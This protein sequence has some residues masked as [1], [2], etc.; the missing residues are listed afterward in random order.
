MP[1]NEKDVAYFASSVK[2]KELKSL[3][4][5]MT[6]EGLLIK[7]IPVFKSGT[8]RGT[9]YSNDYIDR[10][11]IGQFKEEEDIP[12]QA[13]HSP[14][15]LHTL[16]WVKGLQRKSKMMLADFLLTDENAIA[17][18]QKGLMKKFSIGVDTVQEKLREISIVAFPYVKSAHVHSEEIQED[19]PNIESEEVNGTYFVTVEGEQFK[20]EKDDDNFWFLFPMEKRDENGELEQEE[21]IN[22]DDEYIDNIDIKENVDDSEAEKWSAGIRNSLPDSSFLLLKKPVREKNRDRDLPIKDANGVISKSQVQHALDKID[23]VKAFSPDT[24]AK[25]KPKLLRI[26]KKLGIESATDNHS[27]VIMEE[28]KIEG[29]EIL[30]EVAEQAEVLE[31]KIA[32]TETKL[33]EITEENAKL[34]EELKAS[35]IDK[36]LTEL[37]DEGKMLPAQEESTRNFMMSL[38]EDKVEEFISVLRTAKPVVDLS[39]SG[40]ADSGRDED[41]PKALD[42][43]TMSADDINKTAETLAKKEGIDFHDAL[44]LCYDGKVDVNGMLIKSGDEDDVVVED[45]D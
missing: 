41:A 40:Q 24:V 15:V 33:S 20:V 32:T 44:D 23:K 2:A 18:W 11:F 34:K 30:K 10:N 28:K 16:G 43:D 3:P 25:V 6:D 22:V 8:Y 29:E 45:D 4:T 19:V 1:E 36:K 31:A 42:V 7:G 14:S 9:E 39:E 21:E 35:K 38:S 5:E 26:A 13:D 17:R 37:K 27:E 12:V